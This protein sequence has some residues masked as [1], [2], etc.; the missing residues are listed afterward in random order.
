LKRYRFARNYALLIAAV[1]LISTLPFFETA[2]V[3]PLRVIVWI[4]ALILGWA[5]RIWR[6][7]TNRSQNQ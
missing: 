3:I 4:I 5:R 6:Q 7:A 2:Y 1:F